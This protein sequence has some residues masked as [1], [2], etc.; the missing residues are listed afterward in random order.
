MRSRLVAWRSLRVKSPTV[1]VEIVPL[2]RFATHSSAVSRPMPSTQR[3]TVHPFL[4]WG[5]LVAQVRERMMEAQPQ[6]G[7]SEGQEFRPW[8][9]SPLGSLEV[10]A[11]R[12]D[13]V[14]VEAFAAAASAGILHLLDGVSGDAEKLAEGCHKVAVAEAHGETAAALR[15]AVLGC[16]LG[17]VGGLV[18]RL[19]WCVAWRAAAEDADAL[20]L[21]LP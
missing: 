3:V 20:G 21:G 19:A 4:D 9:S 18:H 13:E 10:V 8:A 2:I 16:Q 5:E 6:M 14:P 1:T 12:R 11:A 7:K 15:P 17:K